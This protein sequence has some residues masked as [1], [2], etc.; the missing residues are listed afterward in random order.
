MLQIL[1]NMDILIPDPCAHISTHTS[2]LQL[3]RQLQ[4]MGIFQ[5][6]ELTETFHLFIYLFYDIFFHPCRLINY[7]LSPRFSL[8][9]LFHTNFQFCHT[10]PKVCTNC[11]QTFCKNKASSYSAADKSRKSLLC[12]SSNHS[13][14]VNLLPNFWTSPTALR[15]SV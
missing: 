10:Q 13:S 2:K 4:V 9:Y 1:L 7:F 6:T 3:P 5:F 8:W 15:N 11:A 14:L 12:F